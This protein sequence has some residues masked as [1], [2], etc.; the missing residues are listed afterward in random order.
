MQNGP[1]LHKMVKRPGILTHGRSARDVNIRLY[2]VVSREK[3]TNTLY[4]YSTK[5]GK[6]TCKS[7]ITHVGRVSPLP[8]HSGL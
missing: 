7:N 6:G 4:T 3:H 5:K 2:F 1:G 8:L